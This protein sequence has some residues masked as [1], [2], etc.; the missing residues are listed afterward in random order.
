[1]SEQTLREHVASVVGIVL[2]E[3]HAMGEWDSLQQIEVVLAIEDEFAV[4]IPEGDI[5]RLRSIDDVT[6]HL[7]GLGASR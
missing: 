2:G 3:S 4:T 6:V 5:P 7:E 1:M